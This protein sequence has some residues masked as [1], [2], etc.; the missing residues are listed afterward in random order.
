MEQIRKYVSESMWDYKDDRLK[1]VLCQISDL[2]DEL[3]IRID[4]IE[5]ELKE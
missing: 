2:L 5:E 4:R 3:F 1:S